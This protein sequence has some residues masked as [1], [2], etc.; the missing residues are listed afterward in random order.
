LADHLEEVGL[1]WLAAK[2]ARVT[3]RERQTSKRGRERR[4]R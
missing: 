1:E 3:S 2:M 4:G